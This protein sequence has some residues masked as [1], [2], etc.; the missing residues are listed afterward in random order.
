MPKAGTEVDVSGAAVRGLPRAAIGTFVRRCLA[1]LEASGAVSR[2]VDEVSIAF[3][4][5]AAMRKLNRDFRRKD[6]TTDVLT[7]EGI[8]IDTAGVGDHSLGEIVISIPQARKQA[9]EERHALA[10]EIRYL[11]LHGLI[12]ALG[13]DHE[14]DDGAMNALE[15]KIRAKV[16]LE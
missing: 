9:R 12:H 4:D 14:T 2:R 10:T 15:R 16:G 11:L 13:Y 6:G 7:F 5:D 8:D 1:R 3:V